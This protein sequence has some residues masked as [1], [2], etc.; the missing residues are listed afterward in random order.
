[1]KDSGMGGSGKKQEGIRKKDSYIENLATSRV[2]NSSNNIS[3]S[4][5]EVK[6][7]T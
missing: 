1:M 3:N 2:V 7:L 4:Q 6:R 5:N